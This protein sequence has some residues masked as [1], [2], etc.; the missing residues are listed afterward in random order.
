MHNP[1][2]FGQYSISR[3]LYKISIYKIIFKVTFSG[4]CITYI[5][6]MRSQKCYK[7]AADSYG[8]REKGKNIG[9]SMEKD[10]DRAP[11]LRNLTIHLNQLSVS[12]IMC[13]FLQRLFC[14]IDHPIKTV[15]IFR[16]ADMFL[17][18]FCN[19]PD[20]NLTTTNFYLSFWDR[21]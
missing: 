9:P 17:L 1:E 16:I 13:Q 4:L 15:R 8:I 18:Q 12:Y 7:V 21:K 19:F 11:I 6:Q 5:S 2:K 20:F 10:I 3:E 14:L